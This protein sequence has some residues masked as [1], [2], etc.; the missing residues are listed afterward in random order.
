MVEPP[1]FPPFSD[2]SWD[3][4][5]RQANAAKHG[6]DFSLAKDFDFTNALIRVDNRF[7]YREVREVAIGFIGSRLYILIYT[8]R[9]PLVHVISLR[10]ANDREQKLHD[11]QKK[12]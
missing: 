6:T 2:F 8:R 5:K 11:A 9:Q 10:K 12:A 3:E 7:D 4:P 1:K